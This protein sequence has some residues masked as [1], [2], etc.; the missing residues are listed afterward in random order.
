[1]KRCLAIFSC[2]VMLVLQ[3][4]AFADSHRLHQGDEPARCATQAEIPAD[5]SDSITGTDLDCQHCCH[6]HGTLPAFTTLQLEPA[7][8]T[9]ASESPLVQQHH[10]ANIS[11]RLF[12]R[13][14]ISAV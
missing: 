11:L 2:F 9:I 14:P 7:A 12:L 3:T 4:A 8:L 13:P 6:C 1:M 5:D 10:W